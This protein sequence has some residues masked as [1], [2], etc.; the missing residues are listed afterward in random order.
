[1]HTGKVESWKMSV[2]TGMMWKEKQRKDIG[3]K[4]QSEDIIKYDCK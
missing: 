4:Q 1:M 3:K 2:S